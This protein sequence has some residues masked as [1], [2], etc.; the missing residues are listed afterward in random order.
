MQVIPGGQVG[1][2]EGSWKTVSIGNF[3][4]FLDLEEKFPIVVV[5]QIKENYCE[6]E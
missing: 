5:F 3:L 2:G 6:D 1:M 4:L